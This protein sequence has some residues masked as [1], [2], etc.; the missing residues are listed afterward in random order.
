MD[1]QL[2][3]VVRRA[4]AGQPCFPVRLLAGNQL[5]IGTPCRSTVFFD[6]QDAAV[7]HEVSQEA[8]TGTGWGR[9]AQSQREQRAGE[10]MRPLQEAL[11]AARETA[12]AET[13]ERTTLT[14]SPAQWAPMQG[15]SLALPAV[16]VPLAAIDAWWIAG[17]QELQ[18]RTGGSSWFVGGFVSE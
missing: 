9:K 4:E 8:G 6:A 3:E 16:R 2:V 11:G 10:I 14:L 12:D 7:R 15:N 1:W 18:G 5:F 13:Q 17:A